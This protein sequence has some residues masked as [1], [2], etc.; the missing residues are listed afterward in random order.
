M[1]LIALEAIEKT[2]RR[3]SV[4]VA[5]LRG[6]DLDVEAGEFLCITGPSGS[7]KSTLLNIIGAVDWPT[8]GR[9]LFEGRDMS[10]LTDAEMARFRNRRVGFVFQSYNLLSDLT[11]WE[12][13]A[14]PLLY[15]GFEPAD[16]RGR[17]LKA[18]AAIGLA[19][20][21]DHYPGQLS[22][23][24]EQRVAFA[25]AVVTEP[26]LLVADEPT[27]NLDT[28]AGEQIVKLLLEANSAGTTIVLATHNLQI[29]EVAQKRIVVADGRITEDTR[30]RETEGGHRRLRKGD[31]SQ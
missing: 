6:I 13:V 27:G 12:N 31:V 14:L 11:A 16:R 23:G 29:A 26:D 28:R 8:S 17:A 1:P 30:A 24:E 9:Y 18:L 20:R 7:G 10:K 2:Y 3:G 15:A 19:D 21:A 4:P 22:G 5:A 25:R